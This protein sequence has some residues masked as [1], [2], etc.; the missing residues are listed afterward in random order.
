MLLNLRPRDGNS[1]VR[2]FLDIS[3]ETSDGPPSRRQSPTALFLRR[4][5]YKGRNGSMD[6]CQRPEQCEPKMRV[7]I[8]SR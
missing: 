3:A 6:L 2:S 1:Q 4:R 8:I 7:L 5:R